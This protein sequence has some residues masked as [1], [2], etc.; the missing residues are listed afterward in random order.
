[1]PESQQVFDAQRITEARRCLRSL[2]QAWRGDWS[3]F[4]GRTLRSQL[5]EINI[6]LDGNMSHEGFLKSNGI[7]PE[8]FDWT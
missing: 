4:D 6:V 7:N 2:G 3:E 1:M 8:T 5:E